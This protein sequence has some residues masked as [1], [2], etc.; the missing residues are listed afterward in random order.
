[1]N[2]LKKLN[3]KLMMT[4]ISA[5]LFSIALIFIAYK[6]GPEQ[7]VY[8]ITFLICLSGC[9]LGWIVGILTSPYD[10]A[11]ESKLNKFS[12]LIGT[13]ISGYLLSKLDKVFESIFSPESLLTP[14]I[15]LRVL[16][17]VCFF[18]IMWIIVFVFRQYAD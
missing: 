12:K 1:M 17:F 14:I 4:V 9:I 11:D 7:N 6:I 3:Y 15:G 13:F 16:L 8:P 18:C 5:I 10:K 2:I